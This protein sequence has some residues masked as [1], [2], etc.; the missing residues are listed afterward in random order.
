MCYNEVVLQLGLI[1]YI[2]SQNETDS[3]L[4]TRLDIALLL[5]T[6]A[7]ISVPNTP[8]YTMITQMLYVCYHDQHDTSKT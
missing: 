8:T 4:H 1:F 2:H 3:N 5:D 6:G 7:S